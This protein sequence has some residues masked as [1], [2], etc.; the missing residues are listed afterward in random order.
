MIIRG[1]HAPPFG[2]EPSNQL[3]AM[4]QD[5]FY[6]FLTEGKQLRTNLISHVGAARIRNRHPAIFPESVVT[7][8]IKLLCPPRGLVIDPVAGSGTTIVA[9]RK[10]G[11]SGLGIEIDPQY[12]ASALEWLHRG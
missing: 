9:A 4:E 10:C 1:H 5:G 2:G 3:R 12:H 11:R 7:Q 6:V 8:F